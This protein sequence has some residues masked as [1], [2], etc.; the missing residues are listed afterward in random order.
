MYCA[1]GVDNI[2]AC[3]GDSGGGMFFNID[4]A[5]YLR[6]VVSF[7]P[8]RPNVKLALCDSSKPTVFTDIT[9][10]RNWITRH[11]NTTKWLK[12]LKP[13]S[14]DT[15]EKDTE[16]NA[17]SRIDS[18]FLLAELNGRIFRVPLNGDP[19]VNYGAD[20]NQ[21][22]PAILGYDCS[23][24]RFYWTESATRSIF[25]AKLDG[26]DKKPF[27]TG[28][29]GMPIQPVVD[30]ISRRLYWIDYDKETLEVASLDDPNLRTTVKTNVRVIDRIAVDPLE[31]KVYQTR[32]YQKI[33][34]F[35]LDGSETEEFFDRGESIADMKLSIATG[36]LCYAI[37]G[38]S[39]IECINTRSKEI[40]ILVSNLTDVVTF[41][42][43]V[44][45]V[46][47]ILVDS[48]TI[49]S[50]NHL[51]ERQPPIKLN[52]TVDYFSSLDA[53]TD[54]C[55]VFYSPCA[56]NN[57]NCPGKTICLLNPREP[58]GKICKSIAS[59]TDD[60][61][62]PSTII[63]PRP[64]KPIITDG[65]EAKE[66][67]WPWH[68]A[69][70]SSLQ[71]KTGYLC[72]GSIIDRNTIVTAAHCFYYNTS[73][74]YRVMRENEIS[75]RS[76]SKYVDGFTEATQVSDLA[77][78]IIHHKYN[79]SYPANDI[80]ILKL[81]SDLN[82]T[83][84]VRSVS[85]WSFDSDPNQNVDT[86]GT[87][88]GFGLDEDGE[89]F[90]TLRDTT[91]SVLD[92]NTCLQYD[93]ET[94][95]NLLGRNVYCAFRIDS[96]GA[97]H[98]DGGGGMFFNIN[99]TWYLRGVVSFSPMKP[100]VSIPACDSS[101]PTVF[102]D[103]TKYR[104]WISRYTNTTKWLQDLKPCEDGMI[105]SDTD[106][107]AASRFD[108]G[109]LLAGV[110]ESIIRVPLNGDPAFNVR[111]DSNKNP[112]AGLDFDCVD[113]R[114]YW[115]EYGVRAIFSA[116]FDGTDKKA[117][118]TKDLDPGKIAVD[119]ISRRLYWLDFEKGSI[120]VASLE[121]TSL[122]TTVM[123]NVP[124]YTKI[125]LDV[126]QGKLYKT[127]GYSLITSHNLDGSE[128]EQLITLKESAGTF[129]DM[130]FTMATGEVCYTVSATIECIDTRSKEIRRIVTNFTDVVTFAKTKGEVYWMHENSNTI[131]SIDKRGERQPPK[132]FNWS[133]NIF[134]ALNAV[135]DICPTFYSPCAI[136]NGDCP[137]S[138]ICLLNPRTP[139]GKICKCTENCT[140]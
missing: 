109:F 62:D 23:E 86:N 99:D 1:G 132:M 102:T 77:K 63:K 136:N 111:E 16:C 4:G 9:K 60:Q 110:N 82:I 32:R 36:E 134:T 93:N 70:Y 108:H 120:E 96:V 39:M 72:G 8:S 22:E 139:S 78:I 26:T 41:A 43:T 67:K 80:A 131:E 98:G 37:D 75:V 15:I 6:G 85:I 18:G 14:N 49:E 105:N 50:S 35:N 29:R 3:N 112:L 101:K 44:D 83:N 74:G 13:C 47:W 89:P 115:T 46:Y 122:R 137:E 34:R 17:A 135:T 73:M 114:F 91:L 116:K 90:D 100:N 133:A 130:K 20:F 69:I 30:W 92:T 53:V 38:F 121:N 119:W 21:N 118:I 45:K 31:G 40:R 107:N 104:S 129:K 79:H 2:S 51:G 87:V 76:G 117:F 103:V 11:T 58:S 84:F 138:T 65:T 81:S 94:Y 88:I 123:T 5:W 12:D 33:D 127:R 106:C 48:D 56:D 126:L 124:F 54:E 61:V 68:V 66:S 24:G 42:K 71:N 28:D 97:C 95:G 52:V 19:A 113:G 27:I 25:S 125:A 10:Y 128:P 140:N 57:G 7:S 64:I 59:Q 55:P